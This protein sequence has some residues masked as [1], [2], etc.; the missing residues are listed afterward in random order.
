MLREFLEAAGHCGASI[1]KGGTEAASQLFELTR[2][3]L[4]KRRGAVKSQRQFTKP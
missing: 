4:D 1:V 2:S 3:I